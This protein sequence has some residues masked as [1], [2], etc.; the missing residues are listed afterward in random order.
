[1]GPTVTYGK[2]APP[3]L[4]VPDVGPLRE[5]DPMPAPRPIRPGITAVLALALAV[6]TACSS[7]PEP[8][9]PGMPAD[10]GRIWVGDVETGDLS[11]FADTPWNTVE[12][13]DPT[14]E[15]D[16]AHVRDGEHSIRA[17]IPGAAGTDT[18]SEV[19]PEV[20]N[21]RPGDD[22]YFGFSTLLDD[23]FP[24]D[25]EWQVL[26]QWKNKG[27]GSPPVSLNV[28][29]GQF[30][31]EGGAGHPDGPM[32]YDVPLGEAVPGEWVD[33]VVHIRF[34]PD[35]TQGFVE[36]W[37]DGRLLLAPY[38]PASGTMYPLDGEPE[39]ARSYVKLGYYR[40]G[41]IATPGTVYFDNWVIGGSFEA[42]D[43]TGA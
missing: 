14:V 1:M 25:E 34:S 31:L 22:L 38:Y 9:E 30:F 16:P 2:G 40:N 10:T 28:A 32:Q 35:P 7:G 24:V 23:G 8:D 18:R 5:E 17:T 27:E 15:S 4:S 19:E 43:R 3:T 42:V 11:Q 36:V 29:E 41:D 21:L 37:R 33:W 12:A 26:A 39:A 6:A 20:P 13:E